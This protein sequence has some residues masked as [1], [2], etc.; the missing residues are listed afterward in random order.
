M[1][2]LAQKENKQVQV[3]IFQYK[4]KF[5]NPQIRKP[6]DFKRINH[7][8]LFGIY[9]KFLPNSSTV[10]VTCISNLLNLLTTAKMFFFRQ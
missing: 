1:L 6:C 5:I 10:L 3:H 7:G 9:F 4:I 8:I 2:I